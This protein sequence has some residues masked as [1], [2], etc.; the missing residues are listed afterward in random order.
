MKSRQSA[1]SVASHASRQSQKNSAFGNFLQKSSKA[2]PHALPAISSHQ[3]DSDLESLD[4][5]QCLMDMERL[6]LQG[7]KLSKEWTL[8]DRLDDM[9]FEV[10]RHSLHLD[11][12][13]NINMMRDGMRLLCSGFEMM[14]SRMKFLELDGWA[15]D[16]CTDMDKYDNA[17]GKIYRKYWRKSTQSSPEMEILTGL[18]ASMGM[19]HFKN[20][21]QSKMFSRP[22]SNLNNS[23]F[24]SFSGGNNSSSKPTSTK[25]QIDEESD[26]DEELPP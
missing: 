15:S 2:T 10:R 11:E 23:Q 3:M 22:S 12:I 21:M 16:V 13:N 4:K 19:H 6:K 18:V 1:G 8:N 14:N 26:T 7:I 9:R 5:Q 24:R 25:A 20:K 17:L